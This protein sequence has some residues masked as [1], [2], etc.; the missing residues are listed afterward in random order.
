MV[1]ANDVNGNAAAQFVVP[2]IVSGC[3]LSSTFEHLFGSLRADACIC[4]FAIRVWHDTDQLRSA[5]SELESVTTAHTAA[6]STAQLETHQ[7]KAALTAAQHTA[8]NV[9]EELSLL[10]TQLIGKHSTN[11]IM[12]YC[13]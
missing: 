5:Q 7:A 1:L 2:V 4:N 11:T 8:A 12:T 9:S 10:R 13:F 3:V 6:L